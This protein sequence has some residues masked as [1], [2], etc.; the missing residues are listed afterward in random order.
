MM[1]PYSVRSLERAW[2][3]VALCCHAGVGPSDAKEVSNG[4]RILLKMSSVAGK[5]VSGAGDV[6]GDG[7]AEIVAIFA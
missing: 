1:L 5:A 2:F 6:D 3:A 7:H 4:G